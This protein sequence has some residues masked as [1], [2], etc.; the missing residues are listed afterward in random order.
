MI[1]F[2]CCCRCFFNMYCAYALGNRISNI[3]YLQEDEVFVKGICH[4]NGV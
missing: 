2:C 4:K 3:K 1:V